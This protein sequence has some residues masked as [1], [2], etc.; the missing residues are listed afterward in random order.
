MAIKRLFWGNGANRDI[1]L[2]RG[3]TSRDLTANGLNVEDETGST[4]SA[5]NYLLV[6]PGDHISFTPQFRRTSAPGDD[7]GNSEI[8]IRV[9]QR[10]GAVT[11]SAAHTR[12]KHNFVIEI[13]AHNQDGTTSN[14]ETVRVHVHDS[15]TGA[16]LTPGRLTVRPRASPVPADGEVTSFRFAV[17]ALFDTGVY[18]DL[19]LGHGVQWTSTGPSGADERGRHERPHP[20]RRGRCPG[21]AGAGDHRDPPGGARREDPHGSLRILPTWEQE[22]AR[23]NANIVVGSAWPGI[24]QPDR[25]PNVLFVPDGFRGEDSDRFSGIVD[26][27]VHRLKTDKL[28]RPF[29]LLAT[30]MNFW[31][32]F[33]PADSLGLSFRSE[34]YTF[35][36]NGRLWGVAFPI[37]SRPPSSGSWGIGQLFYAAGLPV[38]ADHDRTAQD[39]KQEWDAVLDVPSWPSNLAGLINDWKFTANR[40]LLEEQDQFPGMSYGYPPAANTDD[41]TWLDLHDDRG[42]NA[43]LRAFTGKLAS[44]EGVTVENGAA[45]GDLWVTNDFKLYDFDNTDL[46]FLVSS[47]NGGRAL[48]SYGYIAMSRGAEGTTI[49][50]KKDGTRS[51]FST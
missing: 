3:S 39:I 48:N 36:E 23:P 6:T 8:G 50:V 25:V 26:R 37:L 2:L 47:L 4:P 49:A 42:G 7:Y 1:H 46:I 16:W 9:D 15:V 12:I 38:P 10:T 20:A 24:V 17:R 33:W 45:V 13:Q 29:D 19:T 21:G 30:S 44:E 11:A 32:V 35:E 31:R 43:G 40:A 22:P 18:G 28:T 34:L 51:G 27:I 14:T 41:N 5:S